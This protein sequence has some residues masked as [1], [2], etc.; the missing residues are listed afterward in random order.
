IGVTVLATQRFP[1]WFWRL[2]LFGLTCGLVFVTWLQYQSIM[3]LGTLCPWCM[4]VWAV[5][6]PLWWTSLT[7][8]WK[9][10]FLGGSATAMRI[11]ASLHSWCWVA[12]LFHVL[13]V[14]VFA[15]LRLDWLFT[16]FGIG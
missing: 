6:I 13:A 4:V 16:E 14:T 15:Q 2:Y 5:M 3:N 9:H 11:G 10:G 12:I 8:L 7:T 1:A